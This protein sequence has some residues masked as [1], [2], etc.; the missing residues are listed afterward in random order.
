MKRPGGKVKHE[1]PVCVRHQKERKDVRLRH[2]FLCDVCSQKWQTD[3]FDNAPPLYVGEPVSGYCLL[4]NR[5]QDGIRLRTWFLCDICHRVAGAIGRSHVSELALV[6]F[7]H[8]NV[9][10]VY[11]KLA[12]VQNDPP[13]LRPRRETDRSGAAPVDFLVRDEDTGNVLFAIENK[14]GRSSIREMSQFQLDVSDCDCILNEMRS[15]GRPV[16]VVHAQV[17]ELWHPPTVGFRAVGMWWTDV[18]RLAEHFVAVRMRRTEMRGAAY[19]SRKAF[20]PIEDFPAALRGERDFAL[21]ERFR[22]E[23]VPQLYRAD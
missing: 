2:Y 23:G 21:V 12:L 22:R 13:D 19:F 20:L 7:W 8:Q 4:C 6:D 14:T 5:H 3:A 16:Y 1:Y 17:V 10:A 9:R 11:P 18:Y 15:H